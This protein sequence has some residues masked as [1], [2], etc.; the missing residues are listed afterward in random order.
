M[1][2][3]VYA[4]RRLQRSI[5]LI[6]FDHQWSL[7]GRVGG[8]YDHYRLLLPTHRWSAFRSAR[9]DESSSQYATVDL[10]M[11]PQADLRV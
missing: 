3:S 6:P 9:R 11:G 5:G 4:H 8:M 2:F 10:Y 1:V 7:A